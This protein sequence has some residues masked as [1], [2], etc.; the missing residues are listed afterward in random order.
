MREE[1][2]AVLELCAY[3]LFAPVYAMFVVLMGAYFGAMSSVAGNMAIVGAV[4]PVVAVWIVVMRRRE[5]RNVEAQTQGF[6]TSPE[7]HSAAL[8]DYLDMLRDEKKEEKTGK[9]GT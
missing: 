1:V 2:R 5:V 7:K 8:D 3:Y 4:A 6:Q 9:Q